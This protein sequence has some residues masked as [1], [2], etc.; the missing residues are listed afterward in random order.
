MVDHS[1]GMGEAPGSNPGESIADRSV[2]SRR[3]ARLLHKDTYCLEGDFAGFKLLR[4]PLQPTTVTSPTRCHQVV[5]HNRLFSE[6]VQMVCIVCVPKE[7]I[8]RI[9][10]EGLEVP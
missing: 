3:T 2:N 10:A 1:L 9:E 8:D 7:A 6:V 4:S 5:S